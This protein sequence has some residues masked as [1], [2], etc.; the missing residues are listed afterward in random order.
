MIDPARV[1]AR[2]L[3]RTKVA[4]LAPDDTLETAIALFEEPGISGAPVV[5]GDG[6]SSRRITAPRCL[7]ASW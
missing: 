3:M 5:A 7:A 4:T 1:K 2:Q 6:L